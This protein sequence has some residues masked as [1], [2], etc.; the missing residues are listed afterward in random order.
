M[1]QR[2]LFPSSA[3]RTT[4]Q[5]AMVELELETHENTTDKAWLLSKT[6]R[7]RDAKFIPRSI[8]QHDPDFPKRFRMKRSDA[9][10]RG[11]L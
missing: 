9:M 6:G 5:D 3:A 2:D 10:Q 1:T 11:W 4:G 7:D 8:V